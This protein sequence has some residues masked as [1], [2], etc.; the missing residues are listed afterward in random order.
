MCAQIVL[1][2]IT[3]DSSSDIISSDE[4]VIES[5]HAATTS[6]TTTTVTTITG[7]VGY[8]TILSKVLLK[9]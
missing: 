9:F 2:I 5:D 8:Q 6:I 4:D 1:H 7:C 3:G